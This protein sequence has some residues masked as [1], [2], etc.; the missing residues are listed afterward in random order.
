MQLLEVEE[1]E[2]TALLTIQ[3]WDPDERYKVDL[4]NII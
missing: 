1:E 2:L 4:F 3:A